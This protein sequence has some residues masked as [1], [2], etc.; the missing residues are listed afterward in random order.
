MR[1]RSQRVNWL[2]PVSADVK[3]DDDLRFEAL[4]LAAVLEQIEN[5]A[6]VSL[7]FLDACREDPFKQRFGL[8]RG[9]IT[10]AGLAPA[11]A[12]ASG[13]YIVFATAPGNGGRGRQRS[14]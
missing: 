1:S 12:T 14:A 9:G 11:H 6:H 13:T 10:R 7:L 2:L 8:A 4:D 5:K 3:G